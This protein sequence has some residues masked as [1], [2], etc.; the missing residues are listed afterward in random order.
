[1]SNRVRI[2]ITVDSDDV[3]VKA[4]GAQQVIAPEA[5]ANIDFGPKVVG[6]DKAP[7]PGSDGK[8][9]VR[10]SV[11]AMGNIQYDPDPSYPQSGQK[12]VIFNATEAA[13]RLDLYLHPFES[14]YSFSIE[15]NTGLEF[16]VAD[17]H[18]NEA[19]GNFIVD[20]IG[21]GGP[22]IIVDGP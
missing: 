18:D 8:S 20:G 13:R 5:N 12:F 19:K 3:V 7:Q 22:K 9:G 16:D 10:I 4:G 11:D 6:P 2:V 15:P 14:L 1:M 17:Y 21:G